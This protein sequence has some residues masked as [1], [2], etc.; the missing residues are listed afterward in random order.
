VSLAFRP[1]SSSS[2]KKDTA[3]QIPEW[4]EIASSSPSAPIQDRSCDHG[5]SIGFDWKKLIIVDDL[6]HPTC[7]ILHT[8]LL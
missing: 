8:E 3:R 5:L 1:Q 4:P 7:G 6:C 2:R